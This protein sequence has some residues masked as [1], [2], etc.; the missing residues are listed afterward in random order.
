MI[1]GGRDVESGG[2]KVGRVGSTGVT[3]VGVTIIPLLELKDDGIETG[4]M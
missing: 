1:G 4:G 2:G 3:T